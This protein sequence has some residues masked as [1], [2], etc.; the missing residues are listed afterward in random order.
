M[1]E[2]ERVENKIGRE[3]TLD[4]VLSIGQY[5]YDRG[6]GYRCTTEELVKLVK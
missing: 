2:I 3:L 4:E 6:L 1:S 5:V